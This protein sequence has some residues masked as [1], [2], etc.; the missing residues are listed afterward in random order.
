MTKRESGAWV[1]NLVILS[2]GDINIGLWSTMLGTGRKAD[3]LAVA[4]TK[5]VKTGCGLL[6]SSK[7]GY[8]S[9]I[10]VLPMMTMTMTTMMMLLPSVYRCSGSTG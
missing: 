10:A 4:K 2:V 3:D 5:D 6:E 7:V 9:K 1:Q 8:G